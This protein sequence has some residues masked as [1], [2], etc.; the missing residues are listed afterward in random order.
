MTVHF[1]DNT[2]ITSGGSL[3]KVLQ[4]KT[5]YINDMVTDTNTSG[6]QAGLFGLGGYRVYGDLNTITITPVSSSSTMILQGISGC[7]N[8]PNSYPAQGAYG[9]VCVLNNSSAGSIDNTNYNAYQLNNLMGN[10]GYLPLVN[11]QGHYAAGNTNEQ[12]WRLKG[13]AYTEGYNTCTIRY[14]NHHLTVW[15]VEI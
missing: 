15:E 6:D 1:G 7:T 8:S 3:G 13:I 11:V 5:N 10:H 12:T 9:I 14:I 4:C 2:S